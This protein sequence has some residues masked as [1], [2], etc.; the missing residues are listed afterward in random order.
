MRSRIR[1]K[2]HLEWA[3][4]LMEEQQPQLAISTLATIVHNY[5]Y[6]YYLANEEAYR[7]ISA[8]NEIPD[9]A[10]YAMGTVIFSFTTIE[11]FISHILQSTGFPIYNKLSEEQKRKIAKARVTERIKYAFQF[12]PDSKVKELKKDQEPFHSFDTLRQL[13]N[14]LIHYTPTKEI[15][16]S[17]DPAYLKQLISLEKKAHSKFEFEDLASLQMAFVYRCFNKN[18]ALWAFELVQPFIDWLCDS[19]NIDRQKLTRHWDLSPK[20]VG[21]VSDESATG[22]T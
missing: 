19:L 5:R 17:D 3:S 9:T 14:F 15:I 18:C 1:G 11:T 8:K 16:S 20:D 4:I 7:A 13:R 2:E 21:K 6:F 22:N 10:R 12:Y